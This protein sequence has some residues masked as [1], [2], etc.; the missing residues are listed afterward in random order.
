M[1]VRVVLLVAVLLVAGGLV[2]D[3]SGRA[4]RTAGSDHTSPAA[5]SA[6]APGGG[7]LCQ[8]IATLPDDAARVR[9]LIGTYGRP[10]PALH[11]RFLS[12]AGAEVA[13]GQLLAGAR[14]GYVT[15]PLRH[16]SGAHVATSAC[17]RVGGSSPVALGGESSPVVTASSVRVNG[18]PQTGTIS[19]FYLRRGSESWWQLL[20]T[21]SRRFGLGKASF[22]GAWTLPL[23]ALML[24]GVWVASIRLLARELR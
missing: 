2:L 13:S 9:L 22:F 3:L 23:A 19:L 11:L 10:V 17:L 8:P 14:Q 7:L 21:L 12:P 6:T 16:L 24:I 5:F 15:I 1:R 20:P 18:R 4:P